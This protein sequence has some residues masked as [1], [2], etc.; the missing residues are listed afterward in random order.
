MNDLRNEPVHNYDVAEADLI[1]GVV[2]HEIPK[3]LAELS[4]LL[5]Q[6]GSDRVRDA[7]RVENLSGRCSC[8]GWRTCWCMGICGR[9]EAREYRSAVYLI[10]RSDYLQKWSVHYG[11]P[12]GAF[13]SDHG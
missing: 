12:S 2:E 9:R 13:F 11:A 5:R 7:G 6:I 4:A 8:L 10:R 1:L 3:M